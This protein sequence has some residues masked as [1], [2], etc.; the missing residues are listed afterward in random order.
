SLVSTALQQGIENV[1]VGIYGGSGKKGWASSRKG[2]LSLLEPTIGNRC[3]NLQYP[4]GTGRRPTHLP[5]LVHPSV[6]E[7]IGGAFGRRTRYRLTRPISMA[8][9]DNRRC[10]LD[11]VG[12]EIADQYGQSLELLVGVT[13]RGVLLQLVEHILHGFRRLPDVAAPKQMAKP[14]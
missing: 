5:L 11:Q 14:R 3:P 12:P 8:V 1:P 13:K 10:I 7:A 4:M 6:H 9:V 2:K